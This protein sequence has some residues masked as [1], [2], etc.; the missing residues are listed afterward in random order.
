MIMTESTQRYVLALEIGEEAIRLSKWQQALAC[1]QTALTGLSQEPRV[2]NGLGDTYR[3]LDDPTRAL[4]FFKEAARL[5]DQATVYL[6][7]MAALQEALGLKSEAAS[8]RMAAGDLFWDRQDYETAEIRWQAA[9][10]LLEESPAIYE[11]LAKACLQRGDS[12]GATGLYLAL[13]GSLRRQGRCLMALH[14]C[15]TAL[16]QFPRAIF[17]PT[18]E[19]AWRCVATRFQPEE[20]T[21]E[22]IDPAN[23][24]KAAVEFAHWQLAVAIHQ[25]TVSTAGHIDP[26]I[27]LHLR[28]GLLNEGRGYMDTAISSYERA[29]ATGITLPALFFVL[30]RLYRLE[31]R[32]QDARA[33]FTLSSRHPFYE[34]AVALPG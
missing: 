12:Q 1:F 7:K 18:T 25:S 14:V 21:E 23:L 24:A 30:G 33:A 3:A 20:Q 29:A 19:E 34:H 13:A 17:W 10:R 8:N 5:D 15:Y 27:Y 11:R 26:E 4:A 28:R 22:E 9:N 2:Y 6:D 16:T 31:G 32:D